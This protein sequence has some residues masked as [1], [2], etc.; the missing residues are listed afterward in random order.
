MG[1]LK[2]SRPSGGSVNSTDGRYVRISSGALRR[3]GWPK[4]TFITMKG[5]SELD[6]LHSAARLLRRLPCR[7]DQSQLTHSPFFKS[8]S[9][10][11]LMVLT[12]CVGPRHPRNFSF[13]FSS[14]SV[15]SKNFSSSSI[16]R[17][18]RRRTSCKSPSKGER[19]GTAKI[20]SFLS[21]EPSVICTSSS[22][23]LGL[24]QSTKPG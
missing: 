13:L 17:V 1:K 21:S 15:A 24:Q 5:W 12:A 14:A 16:A 4:N 23:P 6:L 18:G 3:S 20:R 10:T 8:Y 7:N 22:T 19:S 11:R 2:P 9:E